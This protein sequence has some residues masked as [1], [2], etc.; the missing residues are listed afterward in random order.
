MSDNAE[1]KVDMRT[2]IIIFD[3]DTTEIFGIGDKDNAINE[4]K[5]WIKRRLSK[6]CKI[7]MKCFVSTEEIDVEKIKGEYYKAE[8]KWQKEEQERQEM[9]T[10]KQLKAKYERTSDEQR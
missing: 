7:A 9:E 5:Y 10:L 6:S 4:A 8:R 3:D 2:L 1:K